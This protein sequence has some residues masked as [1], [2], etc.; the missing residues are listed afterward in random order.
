MMQVSEIARVCH[1]VNRA[2]CQ[3]L[4][5]ESQPAWEGA[6]DWQKD[7]A[8]CG[9]QYA[10]DDPSREPSDSHEGWMAQKISD[11]WEYGP[12]KDPDKK[13]HPCMVPYQDLPK[14]QKCKDHIFLGVVRALTSNG[15]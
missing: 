6:P 7:S 1:E 12:V 4:G 11:G 3:S 2:Y 5:D 13:E 10:I 8:I 14:S 15:Q 9:V